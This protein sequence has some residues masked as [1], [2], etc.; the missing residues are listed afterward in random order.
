M[1]RVLVA[2]ASA[3]MRAGLEALIASSP[4]LVVARLPTRSATLAQDIVAARPDV[5]LLE[6]DWRSGDPT[7]SLPARGVEPEAPAMVILADMSQSTWV[8]DALRA[9]AH[10][11]LPRDATSGEIVAAIRSASSGLIT[12][13]PDVVA[14]LMP[15]LATPARTLT[16]ITGMPALTPR[17]IE[18]LEMLAQGLG[19]KIIA[20]QLGISEHTVKFHIGSIFTKLNASSRTEAVTTGARMGLIML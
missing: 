14:M 11:I 19:N 17:E 20:R 3:A 5:V 12:L 1:I 7:T 15:A 9:G 4:D 10:A 2:A 6:L 18:V 13:H 8:A 16:P